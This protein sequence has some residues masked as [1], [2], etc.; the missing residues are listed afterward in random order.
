MLF[1]AMTTAA[2]AAPPGYSVT[3]TDVDGC[4]LSLGPTEADGVV[5]MRAECV[6]RD[7]TLDTWNA[8]M[9]KWGDHDTYFSVIVE[10]NVQRTVG[11]KALVYQKH[12]SKG[13]SDRET[14]LWMQHTVVNGADRYAWTPAKEEPV[15]PADGNV[16]VARSDGYWEA[17][18]DPAGGIRVVHQLSYD[19]GGSVPG[20]LVRWFQT[21]GLEAN[22]TELHASM[23][24]SPPG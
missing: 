10:S 7:I 9:A 3:E 23:K 4:E 1:I 13:I 14:N 11:D 17:K 2:L 20:F 16:A 24:G 18:A 12:R 15:H 8:K 19:P 5:P 6:W 22:V 21:S